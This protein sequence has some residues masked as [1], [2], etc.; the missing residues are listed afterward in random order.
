MPAVSLLQI[1]PF[2]QLA[3]SYCLSSVPP[4][5]VPECSLPPQTPSGLSIH[6]EQQLS[7]DCLPHTC[8][9]HSAT[10]QSLSPPPTLPPSLSFP[11]SGTF[12]QL[13]QDGI[14]VFHSTSTSDALTQEVHSAC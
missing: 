1:V 8:G 9:A 7:T 6:W 14:L 4:A 11:V 3:S 12:I 2:L 13:M 10:S 5:H